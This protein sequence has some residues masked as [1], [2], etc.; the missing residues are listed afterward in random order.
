MIMEQIIKSH[1]ILLQDGSIP[2]YDPFL[3]Q[4]TEIFNSILYD[5]QPTAFMAIMKIN[6]MQKNSDKSS[7][8]Q[9][10]LVRSIETMENKLLEK[11]AQEATQIKTLTV[12]DKNG[13]A[14]KVEID[15]ARDA[16]IKEILQILFNKNN[17]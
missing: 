9:H 6:S 3:P 4:K 14:K 11:K 8:E 2:I 13:K 7:S 5:E 17:A 15:P 10:K 16:E 12:T 1:E